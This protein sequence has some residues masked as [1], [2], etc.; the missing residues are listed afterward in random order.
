[1]GSFWEGHLDIS[2]PV[3]C[4][5]CGRRLRLPP[6][7]PMGYS[8]HRLV[9]HAVRQGMVPVGLAGRVLENLNHPGFLR[10]PGG[11]Y[12]WDDKEGDLDILACCDGHIVVGECKTLDDTPADTGFW[13]VILGQFAETIKVG[14]ACK[15]GFA[16]LAVMADG[17]PADFQGKV[18]ALAGPDMRC[19]LLD[20]QDLEQ[21]ERTL[22]ADE[23]GLPPSLSL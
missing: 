1:M 10:G 23:D 15:A 9:G 7:V 20:K 5:G 16:V 3:L 6:Q 13:E 12:K 14:K 19:L 8:I 22:T 2:K 17:F 21:G 4:P 11:K 18:D